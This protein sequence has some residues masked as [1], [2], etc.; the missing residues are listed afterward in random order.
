VDVGGSLDGAGGVSVPF[1]DPPSPGV[2]GMAVPVLSGAGGEVA[3]GVVVWDGVG[4]PP[5]GAPD[6]DGE[7]PGLQN[8]ADVVRPCTCRSGALVSTV[9][10]VA[11]ARVPSATSTVPG[12]SGGG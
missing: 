6:S 12:V 1:D 2:C 7:A 11:S 9:T 4:T 3:P 10:I 8:D 5:S